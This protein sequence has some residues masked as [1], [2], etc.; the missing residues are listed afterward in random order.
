M[1]QLANESRQ[2]DALHVRHGCWTLREKIVFILQKYVLIGKHLF[3][4][5]RLGQTSTRVGGK[6]VFYDSRFGLAGYQRQLS[7]QYNLLKLARI[8]DPRMVID[9][10]ANVGYFSMMLKEA[11]PHAWI[12]A[13]E[14]APLTFECLAKNVKAYSDIEIHQ[15]ALSDQ[16]GTARMEF[17][18]EHSEV[19]RLSLDG[20]VEVSTDTLDHFV[21]AHGIEHI[22]VLKIDTEGHELQVLRAGK[23]ALALTDH[24]CIEVTIEDN[25]GYTVSSLFGSLV[26]DG[27]NFQ[28]VGFRSFT[29][30]AE[31]ALPAMDCILV[32]I[33]RVSI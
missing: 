21:E 29:G 7:S 1:L 27:Y 16:I 14:P 6:T 4:P 23:K 31:G 5:F 26:G 20:N 11:H 10:G 9:C 30:K 28:L 13:F 25:P 12:H 18:E 22:D 19:S 15:V 8:R 2:L 24:L 32:N 17:S 3:V 33:D